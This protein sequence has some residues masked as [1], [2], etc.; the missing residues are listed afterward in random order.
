M[1]HIL[2]EQAR[3]AL[4]APLRHCPF[5]L[6]RAALENVLN[7]MFARDVEEG[8]LD[9]LEGRTVALEIADLGWHW[10]ITLDTGRLVLRH[11]GCRPDTRIRGAVGEFLAIAA[12][13]R[14]PDTLFFQRRLVVEGDTELGLALKNFL[15]AAQP[16][17]PALR[18]LAAA[19]RRV[20]PA[21][22][23]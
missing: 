15:D 2:V 19:A 21:P 9:F 10:P 6:Q 3:R 7:A 5:G 22:P 1:R 12:G 18:W 13:R 8:E 23:G 4:T 16:E 20:A 11:P 17:L 14:D